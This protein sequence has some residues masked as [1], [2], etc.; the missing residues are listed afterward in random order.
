MGSHLVESDRRQ[1]IPTASAVFP[2]PE[3]PRRV[4][5][6]A[7]IDRA[8]DALDAV[9][10]LLLAESVHQAVQGNLERTQA[11][12]QALTAPEAP[13]EPE[14]IRTPRSGRV[15]TFRARLRST[16]NATDRLVSGAF[17]TRACEPAAQPLARQHLPAP[18]ADR[19]GRCANGMRRR[20]VQSFAGLGLEPIDL[21]LMSGETARRS[22]ER[23]RALR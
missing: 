13:P 14:I 1:L 6:A 3:R 8:H 9:S 7:E 21:V 18:A 11:A 22:V 2:R 4:A 12:L 23:T 10:D 5:I 20:P 15:L 17:T 16:P 19:S